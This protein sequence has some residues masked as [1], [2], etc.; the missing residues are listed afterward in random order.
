MLYEKIPTVP[1][2]RITDPTLRY[3][4]DTY[5]EHLAV[6]TPK[7]VSFNQ[8]R[9]HA[10][11]LH[12]LLRELGVPYEMHVATQVLNNLHDATLVPDITVLAIP[13]YV[14]LEKMSNILVGVNTY[15]TL[16]TG[17]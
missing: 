5:L 14:E 10:G 9:K 15:R 4:R 16:A 11:S 7:P 12:G 13:S 2:S 3:L 8:L 17:Q 1:M 6:A